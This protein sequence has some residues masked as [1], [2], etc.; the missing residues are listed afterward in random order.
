[1]EPYSSPLN[2][3]MFSVCFLCLVLSPSMTERLILSILIHVPK[4]EIDKVSE[5][6]YSP[7]LGRVFPTRLFFPQ[8]DHGLAALGPG[9]TQCG[10]AGEQKHTTPR[11]FAHSKIFSP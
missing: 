8:L 3:Q 6:P 5:S 2:T 4:A 7:Y 1:M 11:A 10:G 9:E